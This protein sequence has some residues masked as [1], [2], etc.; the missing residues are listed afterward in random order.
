MHDIPIKT[1]CFHFFIT[2]FLTEDYSVFMALFVPLCWN[3]ANANKIWENRMVASNRKCKVK[4]KPNRTNS[5]CVEF[6]SICVVNLL[7]IRK[8]MALKFKGS[9]GKKMNFTKN[10]KD[11][12]L[13]KLKKREKTNEKEEKTKQYKRVDDILCQ[14]FCLAMLKSYQFCILKCRHYRIRCWW[15]KDIIH[16][17]LALMNHKSIIEPATSRNINMNTPEKA[18]ECKRSQI[19]QNI[20]NDVKSTQK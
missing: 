18:F 8:K 13:R 3:F 1:S 2:L 9:N 7:H 20:S 6:C 4:K 15:N 16:F 11:I 5:K 10:S 19:L 17:E 14:F 12:W